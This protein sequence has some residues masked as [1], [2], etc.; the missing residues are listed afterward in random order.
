MKEQ[1]TAIQANNDEDDVEYLPALKPGQRRFINLYVT[2]QYTMK[3]ISD[4]LN[5]SHMTLYRWLQ[6]KDIKDA[7]EEMQTQEDEIVRQSLKAVRI[8]ALHKMKKL[9]NSPIDGI[10]YQAARD[11]LDRTGHK[12]PTKQ[13]VKT[14]ITVT[15]EEQLKDALK[16]IEG[17]Q[18]FIEV[19]N[20]EKLT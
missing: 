7:I 18:E 8:D 1:T 16:G 11:I 20:Y 9:L 14:E 10:A 2:G 6:K 3:E 19:D 17:A 15:F 12:A 5:V 13:E 4:L